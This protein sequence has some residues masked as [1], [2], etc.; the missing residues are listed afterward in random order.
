M[1]IIYDVNK[2]VALYSKKNAAAPVKKVTLDVRIDGSS[3]SS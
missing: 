3:C 1:C 2:G